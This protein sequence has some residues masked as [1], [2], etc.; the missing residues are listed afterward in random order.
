MNPLGALFDIVPGIPPSDLA[1]ATPG[2]YISLKNY[3]GVLVVFFKG[4]G[5]AAEPPTLELQQAKA[6]AGTS[7]KDLNGFETIFKKQA[8][9]V[10]DVGVWTK[11]SQTADEDFVGD[12][13]SAVQQGLYAV[14]VP[15]TALDV[16]N[17]FDCLQANV[18]DVGLAAQLGCVLYILVD[19]RYAAAPG[20]TLPSAIVNIAPT[21]P[22]EDPA[23]EPAAEQRH[24]KPAPEQ[25]PAEEDEDEPEA[26]PSKAR[27]RGHHR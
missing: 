7:A 13:T 23:A 24:A 17:G 26:A 2:T 3:G 25:P 22:P 1:T 4:V 10:K 11:V 8:V 21:P 20:S 12:G 15:T 6:V 18:K 9:A 27:S 16:A 19:Q 5:G 14:Y